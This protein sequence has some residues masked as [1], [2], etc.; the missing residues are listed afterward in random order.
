MKLVQKMTILLESYFIIQCIHILFTLTKLFP[1]AYEPGQLVWILFALTSL[2][3]MNW[4][5]ISG[6]VSL[7]DK[8]SSKKTTEYTNLKCNISGYR[9][10]GSFMCI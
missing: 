8:V 10:Y 1:I 9:Y 3:K 2:R 7:S 6:S 4:P 5:L